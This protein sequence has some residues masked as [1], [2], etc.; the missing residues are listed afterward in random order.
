MPLPA[1]PVSSN[2]KMPITVAK[3]PG[4]CRRCRK[5]YLAGTE[6]GK[7]FA[8]HRWMHTSCLVMQLR[9]E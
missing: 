4:F 1:T 7:D 3:A 8:T 6:I 5:R 2:R 9:D